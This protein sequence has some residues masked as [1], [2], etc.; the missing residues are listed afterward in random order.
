MSSVEDLVTSTLPLTLDDVDS[1][2]PLTKSDFLG[3]KSDFSG[4]SPFDDG[5]E[6]IHFDPEVQEAIQKVRLCNANGDRCILHL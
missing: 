2:E 6:L 4:K 3:T 1:A 5:I